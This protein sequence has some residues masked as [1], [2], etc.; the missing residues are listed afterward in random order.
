MAPLATRDRRLKKTVDG[1]GKMSKMRRL[2]TAQPEREANKQ[3]NVL[4]GNK[5][6]VS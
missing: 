6:N 5:R 1:L 2:E 4:D 3:H